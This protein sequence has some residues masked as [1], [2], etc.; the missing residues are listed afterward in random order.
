M[1][2]S[3]RLFLEISHPTGPGWAHPIRRAISGN[4]FL[5]LRDRAWRRNQLSDLA[6]AINTR[7]SY[8]PQLVAF[9]DDNI[10]ELQ[11]ELTQPVVKVHLDSGSAFRFHNTKALHRVLF[12]ATAFIT[13]SRSCFE[14]LAVF[15][16]HFMAFYCRRVI[17]KPKSYNVVA[18]STPKR[19]WV[20]ALRNIRGDLIHARSLFLAYEVNASQTRW[21]PIFSMN[22]R[23]GHFGQRDRIELARLAEMWEGLHDAASAMSRKIAKIAAARKR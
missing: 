11:K 12:G 19:R 18:R 8:L 10:A 3:G 22:W 5:A 6:F 2:Q 9:I 21:A 4:Q 1:R 17:S 7:L 13:E 20:T 14:N 15:Y 16:L 23:P